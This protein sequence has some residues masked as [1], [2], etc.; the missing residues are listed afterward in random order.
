MTT[1]NA[2]N[3]EKPQAAVASSDLLAC[4]IQL[5]EIV[6]GIRSPHDSWRSTHFCGRRLKDTPEWCAFYVALQ[7]C[8][9]AN[10]PA[11]RPPATDV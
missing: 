1:K 2:E 7:K 3:S 8:Q 6:E 5:C 4:A 11:Q 10:A 9:R